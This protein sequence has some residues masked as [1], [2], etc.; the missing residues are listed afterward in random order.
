MNL[1]EQINQ[2][3][4]KA[5]KYDAAVER[6]A[7]LS[8]FIHDWDNDPEALPMNRQAQINPVRELVAFYQNDSAGVRERAKQDGFFA[9]MPVKYV[10]SLYDNKPIT[11]V[12]LFANGDVGI[13]TDCGHEYVSDNIGRGSV[14]FDCLP[15][16]DGVLCELNDPKLSL[17]K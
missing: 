12:R 9:G 2:L 5:A 8:R 17:R 14:D 16:I 6:I 4:Q 15:S 13:T 10:D 1:I 7:A 11:R 3:E